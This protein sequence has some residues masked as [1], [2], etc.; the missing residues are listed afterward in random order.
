MAD[1]PIKIRQSLPIVQGAL[2]SP[3]AYANGSLIKNMIICNNSES[4]QTFS[5]YLTD[6]G[7]ADD[8]NRLIPESFPIAAK[9]IKTYNIDQ[10]LPNNAE[11]HGVC[12]IADEITIHMTGVGFN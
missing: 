10:Y 8:S 7:T 6:S 5:I 2:G 1:N 9:S 11:V 4:D 12:N 3:L